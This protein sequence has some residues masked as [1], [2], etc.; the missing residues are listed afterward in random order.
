MQIAN[1]DTQELLVFE[2]APLFPRTLHDA[3]MRNDFATL[4]LKKNN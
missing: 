1:A 4:W 3:E 2:Q